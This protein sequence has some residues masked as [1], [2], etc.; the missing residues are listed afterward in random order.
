MRNSLLT[1]RSESLLTGLLLAQVPRIMNKW[2][3]F[4]FLFGLCVV[5]AGSET[6][7]KPPRTRRPRDP[8][9]ER[10][11]P[12]ASRMPGARVKCTYVCKG[13]PVRVGYEPEGTFCT[14]KVA[15]WTNVYE[16]DPSA[17]APW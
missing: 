17:F 14:P 16:A 2:L 3:A 1:R 8:N 7:S 4:L 13:S 10:S 15:C 9:C 11:R 6:T 12:L 5:L